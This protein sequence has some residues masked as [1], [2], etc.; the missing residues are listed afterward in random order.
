LR[1]GNLKTEGAVAEGSEGLSRIR[2]PLMQLKIRLLE[3]TARNLQPEIQNAA[4]AG[5]VEGREVAYRRKQ[6][7]VEEIRRLKAELKAENASRT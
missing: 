6:A 3:E 2:I 1:E 5:N 4:A 7:L